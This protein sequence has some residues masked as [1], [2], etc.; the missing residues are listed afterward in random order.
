MIAK[1]AI[2]K[3]AIAK[4]AIAKKA[5]KGNMKLTNFSPQLTIDGRSS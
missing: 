3:K 2:A 5:I 1:K 4:K